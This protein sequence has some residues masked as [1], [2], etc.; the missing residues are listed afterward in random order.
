[1]K[2]RRAWSFLLWAT[3]IGVATDGGQC[4]S[5]IS[6]LVEP[7]VAASGGSAL[8]LCLYQLEGDALYQAQFYRGNREIFRCLANGV[9]KILPL[10]GIVIDMTHSNATQ[11]RLLDVQREVSGKFTCEVTVE[12]SRKPFSTKRGHATLQVVVPPQG[13]LSLEVES[14]SRYRPG[15]LLR[16]ECEAPPSDPPVEMLYLLNDFPVNSSLTQRHND[17]NRLS[18]R[19]RLQRSSFTARGELSLKC[20]AFLSSV[21]RRVAERDIGA[22][23]QPYPQKV[24]SGCAGRYSAQGFCFLRGRASTSWFLALATLP[25]LLAPA[26]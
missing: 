23:P 9:C 12:S 22:T 26:R 14:V 17:S 16:A 7:A 15:D 10:S 4:L 5:D 25:L 6:V 1:M 18:L 3:V 20:V 19:V 13:P 21:Y 24:T 2:G 11:L 8:V